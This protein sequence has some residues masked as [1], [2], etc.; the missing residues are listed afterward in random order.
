MFTWSEKNW[1]IYF[2]TNNS[3]FNVNLFEILRSLVV[4]VDGELEIK[5]YE[6]E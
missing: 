6:V 3:Y 2:Q 5:P 1:Y 4:T